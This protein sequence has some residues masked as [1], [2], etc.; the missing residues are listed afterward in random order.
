MMMNELG[1]KPDG[2]TVPTNSSF[3]DSRGNGRIANAV[4][5]IQ[6][7][8]RRIL[9]SMQTKSGYMVTVEH[10]IFDWMLE[11]SAGLINRYVKGSDGCSACGRVR[12]YETNRSIAE[13]GEKVLYVP[14]T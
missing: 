10:P 9:G 3:G 6:N 7:Q 2:E 14:L 4:Q 11:W 5:R 8:F 13:F 1:Q 12:G